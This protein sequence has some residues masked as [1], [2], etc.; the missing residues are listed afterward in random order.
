MLRIQF[1][2]EDLAR[3]RLLPEPAPLVET[4]F[5]LMALGMRTR[6]P[7]SDQWR[8]TARAVFPAVA[9]PARELVTGFSGALSPTALSPDLD[10]DLAAIRDLSPSQ[11]REETD[12]WYGGRRVAMPPWLRAA[13]TGDRQ[14]EQLLLRAFRSAYATVV[15]PYWADIR[16]HYHA[17]LVARSRVLAC[18]GIGGLLA[19]LIPESRWH[20]NWLEIDSPAQGS[21]LLGG[22]GLV[23]MPAIFWDGSPLVG[24][25]PERP[26]VL[27]YPAG[28]M[29]TIRTSAESDGLAA[30]LGAT[31]AAV[32][33]LLA[34]ASTTGDIARGLGISSPSASQHAS[35]LRGARLVTSR[36]EGQI[37][38]HTVTALGVDLIRAN[39]R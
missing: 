3:T 7:W 28:A 31:R 17:E 18:D 11:A 14:A 29:A 8:H 21:V 23:L 19:T 38:V 16:A 15:E 33:R 26:V 6:A 36:R 1:T 24:D 12:L 27:A 10:E 25:V 35:A 32:L 9:R 20:D 4:K 2:A 13:T 39:A 30:I 5:A 22:R 34:V 37:V